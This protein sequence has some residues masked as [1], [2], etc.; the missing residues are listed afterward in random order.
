MAT[1]LIP[2]GIG[3]FLAFRSWHP[4]ARPDGSLSHW[5]RLQNDVLAFDT[6]GVAREVSELLDDAAQ[7]LRTLALFPPSL[8][9]A[10]AFV[11]VKIARKNPTERKVGASPLREYNYVGYFSL[12]GKRIFEWRPASS[13]ETESKDEACNL[14]QL[15][16]R[17][18]IEQLKKGA[19]GELRIGSLLRWY[20]PQG[21][22][23][24]ETL[25]SLWFGLRRANGILVLGLDYRHLQ[26]IL[27]SPTYPYTMRES[28]AEAYARGNYIY[29]VDDETRFIV[30]P[31]ISHVVGIENTTG[32]WAPSM[33][34]DSEQG[35]F[36]IK[37]KDY[38][39]GILT[40]YFNRLL[41]K[42]FKQNTVD[43]FQAPN[44]LGATRVVSV[45]P[46]YLNEGQ[47]KEGGVFGHV[48]A[49][50]HLDSFEEPKENYFPYY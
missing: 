20:V 42:S 3:I 8:A 4:Q 10:K 47:F 40:Q 34:I 48:V 22:P 41:T 27:F 18:L 46:I 19:P 28:L 9:N 32:T 35:R 1:A 38:Q 45:A 6:M 11:Q 26:E 23:T 24:N 50:C 14:K 49:G 17:P 2:G 13:V 30:H 37:I 15:C 33:K 44:L 39:S 29:I 5:L 36:P 31:K 43:I 16:D 12:E 25:S 7:D 21:S